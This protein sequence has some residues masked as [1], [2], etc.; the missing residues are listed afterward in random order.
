MGG[1]YLANEYWFAVFQLVTAML[2]MGA[3]LTPGDF[4]AILREPKAVTSGTAIQLIMVPLVALAVISAFG[5]AG[6][7]AVGIA[8]IAAIPGGTTSNIFTFFARGNVPLSTTITA[9]TTLACLFTT[10]L[11]LDFLITQYMPADFAMPRVQIMTEIALTLL[12]PLVIGMVYLRLFPG[13]AATFSKWVVRASLL[14]IL[15]IVVGSASSGRLDWQAFGL[16]NSVLVAGLIALLALAS[17]LIC[18]AL[19]LRHADRTAID[20]EV[21]VRNVNLGFMLK[22]SLFPAVIGRP[23]PIGDMVLLTLLLYGTLQLL[24][25]V[26]LILRGRRGAKRGSGLDIAA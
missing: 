14:G 5:I 8:L 22:A 25:A 11:I 20:I 6:G 23:D 1:F 26:A 12:L 4:R 9:V 7:V 10:P 17:W 21:V 19:R 15:M 16:I 24:I 3:T 18:K 13:S 2:G